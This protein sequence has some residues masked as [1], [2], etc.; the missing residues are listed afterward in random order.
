MCLSSSKKE[1]LKTLSRKL[2][3]D[4]TCNLESKA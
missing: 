3:T 4:L 2:N 1:T